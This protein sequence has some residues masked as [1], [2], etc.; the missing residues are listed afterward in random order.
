MDPALPHRRQPHPCGDGFTDAGG[1][2]AGSAT[3]KGSLTNEPGRLTA[4]SV[5]TKGH[6]TAALPMDGNGVTM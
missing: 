3:E 5:P 4:K 6:V 1:Y 2:V